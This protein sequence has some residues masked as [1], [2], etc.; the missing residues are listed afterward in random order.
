VGEH[1]ADAERYGLQGLIIINMQVPQRLPLY[2][3]CQLLQQHSIAATAVILTVS[4][5]KIRT[6]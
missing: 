5:Q 2:N 6:H 1:G 3:G 4:T